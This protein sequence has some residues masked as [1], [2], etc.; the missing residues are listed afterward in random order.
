MPKERILIV[1]DEAATRHSLSILLKRE[2]YQVVVAADALEALARFDELPPALTITDLTMPG[3]H[4]LDLLLRIRQ[5]EPHAAVV[6]MSASSEVASAVDA[7]RAGALDYLVKPLDVDRLLGT[8]ENVM[9]AVR[10]RR[11]SEP[12]ERAAAACCEGIVGASAEMQQLFRSIAQVA[13]TRATVLLTGESGTGK[14]QGS[15]PRSAFSGSSRRQHAR[16]RA[17][18]LR[19]PEDDGGGRWLHTQDCRAARPQHSQGP[20]PPAAVRRGA[21]RQPAEIFVL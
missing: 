9:N 16:A 10:L 6:V 1:D 13:P 11:L 4:G 5:R 12:P 17:R 3:I 20:V 8:V 18:A 19:D 2:G 7:M 21:A 14:D 15:P